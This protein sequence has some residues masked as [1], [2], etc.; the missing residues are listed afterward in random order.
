MD[1][2]VHGILQARILEWVAVPFPRG[3]SQPRNQTTVSC[4]AG[5][6]FTSWA[7]GNPKNTGVGSLSLLQ[8]IFLIEELN[9]VSCIAGGFFTNWAIGEAH[10]QNNIKKKKLEKLLDFKSYCEAMIF[11]TIQYWYQ[12]KQIDQLYR[13]ES[14]NI[15]V[16]IYNQ[17]IFDKDEEAIQWRKN[18]LQQM[19]L[20]NW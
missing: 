7:A 20:N 18:N 5:G 11:K 1:Y 13:I 15:D 4:L 14:S 8:Q 17:F 6:F 12:D 2:T 9:R 19:M 10:S 16:Y 3:C